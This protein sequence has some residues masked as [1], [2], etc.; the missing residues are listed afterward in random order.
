M[1]RHAALVAL[2]ATACSDTGETGDDDSNDSGIPGGSCRVGVTLGGAVDHALSASEDAG[3]GSSFAG[4]TGVHT[5]FLPVDGGTVEA[6][7]IEIDEI[8]AGETGSFPG[9]ARVRLDDGREWVT[10]AGCTFE[11]VEHE[12]E[13]E[14]ADGIANYTLGATGSCEPAEL[15][16]EAEVTISDLSLRTA[17]HWF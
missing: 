12:F 15:A 5:A 11:V 4:D 10:T 8:H 9:I 6:F 17:S 7:T 13:M 1:L 2:L 3:C 14:D 16:G